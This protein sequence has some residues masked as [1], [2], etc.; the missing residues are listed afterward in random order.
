MTKLQWSVLLAA[1]VLVLFLYFVLD[2]KPSSQKNIEAKRAL[3]AVSTDISTLVKAAHEELNSDEMG[4]I[5]ALDSE[6]QKSSDDSVKVEIYK[7]LSGQWYNLNKP[8]IAG[9]YAEKVA[10]IERGALAWS[11]AGT[12]FSICVE[13]EGEEKV[14]NYCAERAVQ[15]LEKA[16]SLEPE[17]L[18]HRIN[19][20][21]VY[22]EVPPEGNPMTGIQ[23]LLDLNKQLPE[24][25]P[26]I[27]QIGRLAMKTGQ[28]EKAAERFESALALEPD[29]ARAVCL[30]A[31]AYTALG[32]NEKAAAYQSRCASKE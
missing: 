12:T 32:N 13:Q 1:G 30:A 20:A 18:Q 15:A 24:N 11:I 21:V 6:L 31:E 26:V 7:K 27:V 10:E 16:I 28:Y 14:R 23:M 2:T 8:A 4:L 19:L 5:H 9:Y 25:V 22:A 29:N 3:S 17:N